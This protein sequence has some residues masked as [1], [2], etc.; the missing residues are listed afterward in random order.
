MDMSQYKY[1]NF[2]ETLASK[3]KLV[4]TEQLNNIT[5]N[6]NKDYYL[7]IFKY[8]EEQK[9][10]AETSGSVASIKDVVTDTLVWDFDSESNIEKARQDT[11]EL[12]RRLVN[13]YNV[14]PDIIYCYTSGNK[15]FHVIVPI[16]KE[17]TPEQFKH[18]ICEVAKGLETFDSSV[19]DH[20]RILRLE[21]TK[22][23]KSGLYK[24]PLHLAEIE[25]MS[26][27][28]IKETAK[29]DRDEDQAG[30]KKGTA[31]LSEKLFTVPEKKK[32]TTKLELVSASDISNPPKGWKPYKWAIAQ[33]MFDSGERHNALMVLAATC[34]ALGY[35]KE[36]TYYMCKSALKKQ[37]R[38][39][40]QDEFPKEELWENII[41]ESVFSDRWEGGQYSPKTNPWL[42]KY[43]DRMGFVTE[44]A[45]E[46][47]C[48]SLDT[49]TEQFTDY[50]TNF[51]QNIIKTGITELD[52]NVM[53]STSTL[54][55]LL[56]QPGSGKTT[57]AINYL[58]NTSKGGVPSVFLSLDMGAP[59]VY[60]KLVQKATGYSFKKAMELFRSSPE[61][62]KEIAN[63]IKNDYR[64]VGF[65]FKSG[66]TVSDIKD[67]INKQTESTG[68]RPRLLVI[69]YLECLAGPYSDATANAALIANQ[70]KDLANEEELCILLLLQTQK[71][72]TPDVSD[73]LLSMKQIKG[74]SV[75]EQACSTVLTLW[76]EGYNPSFIDDDKYISFAVVKN[77][78]GSLWRGDFSWEPV[79]GDIRSLSE[80]E[81]EELQDFRKRKKEQKAKEAEENSQW[82]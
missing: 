50:A 56:G 43:C 9:K 38:R 72:S 79:R 74:S 17:I 42:K 14:D 26:V 48:V 67:I 80:E 18:A 70:L 68:L 36:Q 49:L 12:G 39:F 5:L 20:A 28:Q 3:P 55:G 13:D 63:G 44:D 40:G 33:G 25:E 41:E 34:R 6:P 81:Q 52:G 77:R 16:N 7:S 82:Q 15:G 24:I 75:I 51:E 66:L 23:P 69:D 47:V 53:F 58:L 60:A 35:D 62:A 78:F 54:N 4:T 71:H 10:N 29:Q 1:Y 59:I 21:H 64:N 37:A 46:P 27:E 65:N 61:K 19:S 8:N 57:M 73:P 76:R 45:E 22:H 32:E 2:K 11:L 30:F 31:M